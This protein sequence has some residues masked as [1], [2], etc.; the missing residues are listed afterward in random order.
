ME[1][2]AAAIRA[3][4]LMIVNR[5]DQVVTPMTSLQFAKLLK[6][7]VAELDSNCGHGAGA[8]DCER[9]RIRQTVA[10]FLQ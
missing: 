5:Q 6:A 3:Q 2:A 4:V 7:Q 1:R 9:P 10:D 8:A